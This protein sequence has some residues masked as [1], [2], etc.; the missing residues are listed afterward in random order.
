MASTTDPNHGKKPADRDVHEL[1]AAGVV[2]LD[3]PSG[4]TSHQVAAWLRDALQVKQ[5]G[6]GGT[7]D[8]KVTGVLP[9]AVNGAVR[10]IRALLSSGKEYIAVLRL[11]DDVP[12]DKIRQVLPKQFIGKVQQTPPVRSAVARRPRIRRVYY[13][14]ILD[15]QGRDVLF[16]AGCQAGTYVRTLCTDM[17]KALGT[18]GH[19][20]ELRRSRTGLFTEDMAVNLHDVRDARHFLEDGDDSW[21]KQVIRPVEDVV[22]HLPKIV[23]RDSAVDAIC[24]GAPLAT[25]GIAQL[26]AGIEAG[27][28]V[29]LETLKGEL[30]ALAEAKMT[31]Q[32]AISEEKGIGAETDRVVMRPGTYPRAWKKR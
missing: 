13:L 5:V 26:D 9:I 18:R 15:I 6:H 32:K 1:L 23:L 3:K 4:P 24:H 22:A 14:D 30:V 19:M 7:L 16:R 27:E 2:C 31:S 29:A 25:I 10:T 11:H 21:M 28:L 17:G 12:E 20:Q 8:P